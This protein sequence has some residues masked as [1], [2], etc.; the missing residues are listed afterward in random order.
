MKLA[1][2]QLLKNPGFTAVAVLTLAL[3][4]GANLSIYAVVDAILVRPLPFPDSERLVTIYN[5]YPK[6][7]VTK[8]EASVANFYER[9][10][11][12][13]AISH[14]G[15]MKESTA[16]VGEAGSSEQETTMR[17]SPGFFATLGVNL[18]L[19]R[20]FGEEEMNYQSDRVAILTDSYW[21]ERLQGHMGVVGRTIRM[22]GSAR[23][24]VGVLPPHYR[25]LSSKARI[26]TPLSSAPLDRTAAQRH[27]NL[28]YVLIGRL[29]PGVSLA[30]AQAQIDAH[31]DAHM[32]ESPDAK[33]V[34][35]AGFRTVVA[36]L[37]SDHVASIGQTLWLLQSGALFLLLI[38]VVNLVNLLLVRA[39]GRTRELSIR[40]TL[41]ANRNHVVRQVVAE[42]VLLTLIG[43]IAGL[44]LGAAGIQ[45]LSQLGVEQLP[46]G[47]EVSF[48]ARLA[49]VPILGS[50]VLGIGIALPIAWFNLRC[51]LARVLRSESR[52]GTASPAAQHLR[53]SFVVAQVALAMILL[54][55]AGLFTLSL[56]RVTEVSPGFRA[57][58]VLAGR[59]RLPFKGYPS[60]QARS[61]FAQRLVEETGRVPGV[62][63]VGVIDCVP[64]SGE[65]ES[66]SA[67][68][69]EG[70]V[71]RSGE[72]F[73][74]HLTYGVSGDYFPATAIPLIEGRFLDSSDSQRDALI[75]VV[76]KEFA[77]RYWP[78]GTAL[79]RRLFQSATKGPDTQAYTI[80]GVVGTVKASALTD[81]R[82]LGAVYFP[83]PYRDASKIFVVAR[84]LQRPESFG[85][86][87]R[88]VVREIDPELPVYDLRAMEARIDGSL[89]AQ[90]SSALLA[91][92]FAAVA[93]LLGGIGVYGVLSFAVAQRRR[94]IGV[95]M[96]LG[97]LPQAIARHFLSQGLRLLL[98]GSVLGLLGSWFA[99]RLMQGIL[100]NVPGMPWSIAAIALCV[101][102]F[103]TLVACWLPARRAA[104]VDPMEALRDG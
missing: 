26:I 52:G 100:F 85:N 92:I 70:H 47:A 68:F 42:T 38:G 104:R 61:S 22:D 59:I 99:G 74:T 37:H 43:G 19:G 39:S 63:S 41:G 24:I 21:R 1:L 58:N 57:E 2:R 49:L 44:V 34:A 25:F 30:Q 94:E 20:E 78:N 45:L 50:V 10:G 12:I 72:S 77:E 97:A 80:V 66:T 31:D 9:R 75:C 62:A 23:T 83:Y 55:G 65:G 18:I 79:G 102:T 15:L 17:V 3:G 4:I 89:V 71:L 16:I 33:L 40:Q 69:V 35:D 93:A 56:K 27:S 90:R 54:T 76:D 98:I 67:I 51:D 103:V 64:F 28:D 32:V 87:L 91:G 88:A 84:T 81:T 36:D 95:R 11:E 48:D 73:R 46:L 86:T 96:A 60:I 29:K 7:G 82:A 14:W 101:I 6:A 8:G 5:T 53:Q 13:A